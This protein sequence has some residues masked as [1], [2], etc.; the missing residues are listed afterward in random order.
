MDSQGNLYGTTNGGGYVDSGYCR[1]GCGTVFKLDPNGTLITL[2]AF[3]GTDGG[4][5]LS[6]VTLA[7]DGTIYGASDGGGANLAGTIFALKP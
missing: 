4:G 5:M 2:H 6:G 1:Y 7:P 3:N